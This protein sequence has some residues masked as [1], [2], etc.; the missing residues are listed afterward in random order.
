M[1][2]EDIAVT[3]A[4]ALDAKKGKDIVVLRVDEMTVITDYMV[5]ATGHSAIQVKALAENVEEELAK[6]GIR[7][8]KRV[9]NI[10]LNYERGRIEYLELIE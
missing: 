1:R 6:Q 7:I 10:L 4:K 8:D 5:I 3:A 9:I 2:I